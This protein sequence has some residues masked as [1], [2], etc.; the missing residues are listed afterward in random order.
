[1][2]CLKITYQIIDGGSGIIQVEPDGTLNG[3]VLKAEETNWKK[4]LH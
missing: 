4:T 1:M 3:F 2:C